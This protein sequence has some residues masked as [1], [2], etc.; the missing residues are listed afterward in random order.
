MSG[1]MTEAPVRAERRT[2]RA[3]G[4]ATRTLARVEAVR[5]LRHPA[6]LAAFGLYLAQWAYSG[7]SGDDRYP[8][9]HDEDRY[10]QLSLLLIA[11]GTLLAANLAALRSYRHGTDAMFDLL[12]LPPW[13]RTWALLLALLPVTVLSAV[14]AG[15]RIGYTAAQDAAI[16]S[17]SVAELA[18]GPLVVLLAGA[19]GVLAARVVR[20]MV[21]APLTLAALG[22]VTVVG[23]LQ[24]KSD[25]RWWGLVGIEDENVPP[26]PTSLT[27]RPA[28]WHLLYL[29]AL[30]TLVAAAAV[31]RAGGR[32]TVFRAT[33]G[34]ALLA[35]IGTGLAQQRGLP[36]E[37]REARTTAEN[38]PSSQQVCVERDGVDHC[39]FPEFK[40]RYR[41]W[42][43]VTGGVLRW[44]PR[45]AREKR[46]VVRQH[47][48]LSTVG[49]GVVPPLPVAKWAADDR[50]AGTPGA[51]PV[52]TDWGTH[53]DL[54]GDHMLGFAGSFAY[55]AVT[56]EAPADA[57]N[58]AVCRARGALTLWLAV[59]ATDGTREAYDSLTGRSFGGLSLNTF[60]AATGLG[61]SAREQDLVRTLLTRRDAEV[62]AKVKQSWTRLTAADTTTDE[63]AALLGVP[64]PP[65]ARDGEEGRC[66]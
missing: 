34:V 9:L 29:A 6:V 7:Y 32:S 17:P 52:G 45:T 55:R 56:G 18:T 15:A 40:D 54:A 47:V 33:A 2:P 16:G 11:A 26:L 64:A 41:Q 35:V 39:A 44:V 59:Q 19:I 20:S 58:Q 23:A 4:A 3:A 63:A 25:V 12:V 30:V 5:L 49:T 10:T 60:N 28:G 14:L 21:A 38:A 50:A 24:P 65:A 66:A 42:A 62:G 31:L 57:R 46:Y 53:S 43:E 37:V 61:V 51:V 48:F 1:T 27:Y 8:V 36:D 13:R 22:I